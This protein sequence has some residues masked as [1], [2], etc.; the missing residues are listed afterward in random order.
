M[1]QPRQ[2]LGCQPC[3]VVVIR[4]D[5]IA[6]G[7]AEQAIDE[8]VRLLRGDRGLGSQVSTKMIPSTGRA[9]KARTLSA[10][11]AGFQSELVRMME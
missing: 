6:V 11:T 3:P 1:T 2:V 4:A 8:D 9:M 10:S 5:T 7:N